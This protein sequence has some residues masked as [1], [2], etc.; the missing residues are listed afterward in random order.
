MRIPVALACVLLPIAASAQ[1][2][3]QSPTSNQSVKIATGLTYQTLIPAGKNMRS[4][5]M[6]NN[7]GTDSCWIEVSGLVTSGMTTGSSVTPV[8]L[9]AITA[10]QASIFLPAGASYSRYYPLIPSGPIVGT[11]AANTDSIYLDI[12]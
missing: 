5:T 4:L 7:N 10:Q 2:A 8:G 12:Q 1:Q 11:C 6:Q 3:N 9:P